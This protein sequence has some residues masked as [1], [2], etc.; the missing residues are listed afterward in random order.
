M[1]ASPTA[2]LRHLASLRPSR[3]LH[4]SAFDRFDE[5]LYLV[6][7]APDLTLPDFGR[8]LIIGNVTVAKRPSGQPQGANNP[9]RPV[10]F[11]ASLAARSVLHDLAAYQPVRPWTVVCAGIVTFS[12]DAKFSSL[13]RPKLPSGRSPAYGSPC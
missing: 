5:I 6:E 12:H 2:T 11:P 13:T 3:A 1:R 9:L 4:V 8:S 7:K 10:R